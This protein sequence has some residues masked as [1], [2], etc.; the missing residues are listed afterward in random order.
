MKKIWSIISVILVVLAVVFK[1]IIYSKGK[2]ELANLRQSAEQGNADAQSN[3]GDLYFSGKSVSANRAIAAKWYLK[4]AE[5][6]DARAQLN[7]GYLY[8]SGEG[9]PKDEAEGEKWYRKS[10][11]NGNADAQYSLGL[12]YMSEFGRFLDIPKDDAEAVKWFSES[13]EQ[14]HARGQRLLSTMYY[15]GY[16]VPV[17]NVAAHMWCNLALA[18]GD[19]IAKLVIDEISAEMT[20]EQIAEAQKMSREWMAKHS[21]K[22]K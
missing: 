4:A 15:L 19:E 18:Q 1:V 12:M 13:A 3:L 9:I 16:G 20:E 21:E 22:N 5:Q 6:G 17:N 2:Q 8:S 7:L 14:G 11:E 10:A